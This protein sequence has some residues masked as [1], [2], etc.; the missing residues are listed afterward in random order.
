MKLKKRVVSSC[1]SLHSN[2]RPDQMKWYRVEKRGTQARRPYRWPL[3]FGRNVLLTVFSAFD[4]PEFVFGGYGS[5]MHWRFTLQN[6][7]IDCWYL[8]DMV[9]RRNISAF[10]RR[11]WQQVWGKLQGVAMRYFW[12]LGIPWRIWMLQW[13]DIFESFGVFERLTCCLHNDSARMCLSSDRHQV[14][15]LSFYNPFCRS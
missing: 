15:L 8:R 13:E 12:S 14:R 7:I 6:E 2:Y 4:H 11:V 10:V 9:A 3:R 5:W 1:S